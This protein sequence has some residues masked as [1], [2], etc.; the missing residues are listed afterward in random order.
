MALLH[1]VGLD[2]RLSV[3]ARS[4]GAACPRREQAATAHGAT[5]R[6]LLA[7]RR[8]RA[9]SVRGRRRYAPRRG[10]RPWS[11]GARSGSSS[12]RAGPRSTTRSSAIS[13]ASA[14][15]PGLPWPTSGRPIPAAR[16][17]ST[18]RGRSSD[19]RRAGG[20]P[21]ARGWVSRLRRHGSAVQRPAAAHDGRRPARGDPREPP[22]RLRD[23][24]RGSGRSRQRAR[25]R[26]VPRSDDG[27]AWRSCIGS[28]EP[29]A[30]RR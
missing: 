28:C 29:G 18:P 10:D 7:D 12:T 21:D 6:V 11:R 19:R 1:E 20:P 15:V 3:R 26:G 5:H 22:H 13:S 30:T 27:R 24:D 2:D 16:A 17:G 4:R 8:A 25:L 9:R 14:M 23:G